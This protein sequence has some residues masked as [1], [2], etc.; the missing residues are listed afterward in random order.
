[1]REV[2]E[3][4]IEVRGNVVDF[5]LSPALASLRLPVVHLLLKL[6]PVPHLR[7]RALVEF[8]AVAC[9]AVGLE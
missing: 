8:G 6:E 5:R 4:L 7:S 3:P 9:D 2:V 1:M